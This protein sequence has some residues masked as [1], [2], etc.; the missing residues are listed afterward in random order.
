MILSNH[1]S[2]WLTLMEGLKVFF[3]QARSRPGG[4]AWNLTNALFIS[5]GYFMGRCKTIRW[6]LSNE[7]SP[8]ARHDFFYSAE[9]VLKQPRILRQT[10]EFGTFIGIEIER[11][12][13][14]IL[15]KG[16]IST[17]QK[18]RLLLYQ[19]KMEYDQALLTTFRHQ[20]IAWLNDQGSECLGPIY[21]VKWTS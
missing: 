11:R 10:V 12:S 16:H 18:K 8:Q 6:F 14:I 15:N 17:A 20:I 3:V 1:T 9:E 2:G 21:L 13:P 7:A 4:T 5:D 19:M